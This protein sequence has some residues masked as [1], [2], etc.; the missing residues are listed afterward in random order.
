MDQTESKLDHA[1][2]DSADKSTT[3]KISQNKFIWLI[4]LVLIAVG[5]NYLVKLLLPVI[6]CTPGINNA[7]CLPILSIES[8]IVGAIVSCI[9]LPFA[10]RIFVDQLRHVRGKVSPIS[11]LILLVMFMATIWLTWNWLT[12]VGSLIN[13]FAG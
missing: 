10:W 6:P 13:R 7:N 12:Q 9:P 5:L 4:G 2:T 11:W 1:Q 3:S 8:L